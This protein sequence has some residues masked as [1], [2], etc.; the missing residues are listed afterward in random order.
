M[1]AILWI[2]GIA[3]TLFFGSIAFL[4]WR[5][6]VRRRFPHTLVL[7]TSEVAA[8]AYCKVQLP[9]ALRRHSIAGRELRVSTPELLQL[10]SEVMALAQARIGRAARA[11]LAGRGSQTLSGHT[12]ALGTLAGYLASC[13][14]KL[15]QTGDISEAAELAATANMAHTP[16]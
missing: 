1:T 11:V 14:M 13:K 16:G 6:W 3:L 2:V 4:Q 10:E 8:L 12:H 9:H 5:E 7:L 15:A